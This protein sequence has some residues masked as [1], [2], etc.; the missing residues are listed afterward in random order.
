MVYLP[1]QPGHRLT[2][3]LTAELSPQQLDAIHKAFESGAF[4]QFPTP[5]AELYIKDKPEYHGLTHAEIRRAE[6]REEPF[7]LIDK[8]TPDDGGIWYID[9]FAG[10]DQV[11]DEQAEST[12]VLWKIR[13]KIEHVPI[14][15]ANYD[16]GNA[17]IGEDLSNVGVD[18]P[19]KEDFV[20]EELVTSGIDLEEFKYEQHCWITAEP[21]EYEEITDEEIL[22]TALP[23]TDKLY[24]LKEDIAKANGLLTR[25][26]AGCD[27]EST[28]LPDGTTRA[29]PKGSLILQLRYNP[30][31]PWPPYVRPEGSL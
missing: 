15:H 9:D 2:A 11:E 4:S 23:K 28:Q 7:L 1:R 31:F 29:F 5:L 17:D 14:L 26:T 19:I 16:I 13:I 24:R 30:D 22:E 20:Q 21:G 25:W 10:E 3:F 6:E 12:D 8:E 18:L 27:A